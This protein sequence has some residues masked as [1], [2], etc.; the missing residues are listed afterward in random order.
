MRTIFI[1]GCSSGIGLEACLYLRGVGFSVV[2][3]ARKPTDVDK[4]REMGFPTVLMDASS[5]QSVTAG[6]TEAVRL[7][8]GKLDCVFC[9]AGEAVPGAIEDL[10][11]ASMREQFESNFFGTHQLVALAVRH[12]REHGGAGRVVVNSSVL[13]FVAM[14]FRGAYACSK[15]ALESM[16]D[17]LRLEL[18]ATAIHV[19]LLQ[20]GPIL[21]RFRA[22]SLINFNRHVDAAAS[23]HHETYGALVARLGKPGAAVP[24][25]LPSSS[26]M[27]P[28]H[29]ALCSPRPRARYRVTKLTTMMVFL[30]WLLPTSILDRILA[31]KV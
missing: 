14:P 9:N 7:A 2:A 8:G 27:P 5:D 12:M 26:C 15:F 18:A 29:H 31:K 13:G 22:T 17:A 1:T 19:S 11:R 10:S 25:T 6:F 20:P 3:S 4:L 16:C 21:T 30:R 23:A 24:F 28:L